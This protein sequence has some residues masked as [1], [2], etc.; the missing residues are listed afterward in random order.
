MGPFSGL[1]VLLSV[2]VHVLQWC[3][4][5]NYRSLDFSPHSKIGN[6]ITI[7]SAVCTFVGKGTLSVFL[8]F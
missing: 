7:I 2:L 1:T 4:R 8:I 3:D 6:F 5:L